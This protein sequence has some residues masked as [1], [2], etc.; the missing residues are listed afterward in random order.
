VYPNGD[1]E[2]C[3]GGGLAITKKTDGTLVTRDWL[4]KQ[5]TNKPDGTTLTENTDGTWF[6]TFPKK[7]DGSQKAYNSDG[8]KCVRMQVVK[9]FLV[10]NGLSG[11]CPPTVTS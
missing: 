6:I 10:I 1:T 7:T 5:V 4:G 3:C 8:T 11:K 2:T 9:S